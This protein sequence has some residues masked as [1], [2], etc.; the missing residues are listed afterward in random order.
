MQAL[1]VRHFRVEF[2]NKRRSSDATVCQIPP[3]VGGEITGTSYRDLKP[4][5]SGRHARPDGRPAVLKSTR[6]SRGT[7]LHLSSNNNLNQQ[8]LN[9]SLS[10]HDLSRSRRREEADFGMR[11]PAS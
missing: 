5:T 8:P 3:V 2:L 11:A 9:Q 7:R 6:S 1:G 10:L 4:S